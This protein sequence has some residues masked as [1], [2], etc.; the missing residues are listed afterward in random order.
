MI[1]DG[2]VSGNDQAV[3]F[4]L[5]LSRRDFCDLTVR[6]SLAIGF[7]NP[8]YENQFHRLNSPGWLILSEAAS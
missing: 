3:H 8:L 4:S 7:D 6:F 1:P 2:I 5:F